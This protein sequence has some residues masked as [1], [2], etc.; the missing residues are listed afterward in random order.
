ML[1]LNGPILC[2]ALLA[3]DPASDPQKA[4][5]AQDSQ[6]GAPSER[7]AATETASLRTLL[8]EA[9]LAHQIPALAAVATRADAVLELAAAGVRRE[10]KADPVTALDLFHIGSDGKAITATVIALLVERGKMSWTTTPLELFPEWKDEILQDYRDITLTDLLSHHAGLPAYNDD[11][12]PEFR[13]V[14]KLA[15][16]PSEQR[17]EFARRALRHKPAVPPRSQQLYSNGGYA[18]A[19]AMAERVAGKS[20]EALVRALLFEP[21]GIQ[22]VFDWP[23]F[24]DAHQPWGHYETKRSV[25]RHNPHDKYQLPAFIVPAGALSIAPGDYA[26]FLQ[27]HLKGLEGT[28]GLL[29]A[30]TIRHLHTP[31]HDK[32]ALGW[33]VQELAGASASVHSGSGGTFYA[34]VA[35]WPTRDLAVAVFANAGGDRASKACS[36]ILRAMAHRYDSRVTESR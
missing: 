24:H 36:S 20:W 25:R 32:T 4:A 8:E 11:E 14:R 26:K 28:N 13:E 15:G 17:R 31:A 16:T 21:L 33:G 6:E 18:I 2:L 34:V 1:N 9:R 27:L 22:A 10:G 12:S 23:A 29:E 35:V 19:G 5:P 30:E 7:M 3:T